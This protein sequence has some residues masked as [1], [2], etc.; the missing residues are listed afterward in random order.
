V[1]HLVGRM[2]GV[3]RESR[4]ERPIAR[5]DESSVVSFW[6]L[7][8]QVVLEAGRHGLATPGFRSPPRLQGASRTLRRY[9]S[10]HC[11]VS[12][13]RR[14]RAADDVLADMV[15]GVLAANGLR[16]SEVERWRAQLME[17]LAVP[18]RRAA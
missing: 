18:A 4:A 1:S 2:G 9:P 15:D 13:E 8:R 12:V 6:E 16:G 17:A 14:G 5:V 10:G 7:A 11:L 3:E